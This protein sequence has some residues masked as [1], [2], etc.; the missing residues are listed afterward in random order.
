MSVATKRVSS[1][2][3]IIRLLTRTYG[4]ELEIWTKGA[5]IDKVEVYRSAAFDLDH[6]R[7]KGG[8][9]NILQVALNDPDGF[10]GLVTAIKDCLT[11][12]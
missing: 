8:L 4:I 2:H 5:F 3:F 12:Q 11:P 7:Q 6:K 10:N 1:E 9:R